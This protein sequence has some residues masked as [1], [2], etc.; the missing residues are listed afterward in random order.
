VKPDE[1]ELLLALARMPDGV[2]PRD[3]PALRK[4][5]RKRAAYLLGKWADRGWYDYGVS[6]DLGWLTA[7]GVVKARELAAGVTVVREGRA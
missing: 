1:R 5:P 3:L 2:F 6:L 7:S 4:L